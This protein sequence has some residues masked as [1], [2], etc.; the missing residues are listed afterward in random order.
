MYID[1]EKTRGL[2]IEDE[3]RGTLIDVAVAVD[4]DKFFNLFKNILNI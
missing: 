4:K 2:T 1:L 3:T